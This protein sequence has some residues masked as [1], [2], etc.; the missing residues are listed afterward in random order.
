MM[1]KK[2]AVRLLIIDD[3]KDFLAT[4]SY[5]LTSRGYD[6]IMANGGAEALAKLSQAA[7]DIIFLDIVMPRL[8]GMETLRRLRAM[9]VKSPVVLLTTTGQDPAS[10]IDFQ[11][12]GI[13]GVFQK[14]GSLAAFAQVLEAALKARPSSNR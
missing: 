14:Q 13:S 10:L 12:L 3:E 7:F 4:I 6:V 11:A 5:W 9:G 1:D 2:Q 8:N